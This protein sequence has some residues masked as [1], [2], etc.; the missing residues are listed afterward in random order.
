MKKKEL[1]LDLKLNKTIFNYINN[2]GTFFHKLQR[3]MFGFKLLS[4]LSVHVSMYCRSTWPIAKPKL[5]VG[6]SCGTPPLFSPV[7]PT[8]IQE[9]FQHLVLVQLPQWSP[10]LKLTRGECYHDP[11]NLHAQFPRSRKSGTDRWRHAIESKR[12]YI[13]CKGRDVA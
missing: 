2:E 5:D 13:E 6:W 11:K 3:A 7:F 4:V 8:S 12:D 10:I 9:L 1:K